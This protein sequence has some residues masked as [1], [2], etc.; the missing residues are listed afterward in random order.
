MIQFYA[1]G[2][3]RRTTIDR[4][5]TERWIGV[6][7]PGTV[8]DPSTLDEG[9]TR[10][11]EWG[12]AVR[13]DDTITAKDR[14]FAGSDET[15]ANA[16]LRLIQDPS[17]GAIWCAR[18]GYGATRILKLLDAGRAPAHLAKNP[19]LLLG[20][21][22]VTA[23]H[24]YFYLHG[25]P[26]VHGP[27][28]GTKA[29]ASL[30]LRTEKILRRILK[31]TMEL[32]AASHTAQWKP[33]FLCAP[34][35]EAEGILVGGSLTLLTSLVGTPW[36]PNLDGAIL[37]LE[38]C[39]EAPYRVDRMLTQLDNAGMLKKIRGVLLGD[40][41]D[42]VVYRDAAER[43]NWKPIFQERFAALNVPVLAGLPFGHAKRNEPVPVGVKAR[44]TKAGKIELLEQPVRA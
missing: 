15:R 44:I 32:G 39:G 8:I 16:L 42:G 33:K 37:F 40:F 11:A 41:E 43:K 17:V 19:K 30:D 4:H 2:I 22:D 36:Q 18:G 20:F 24:L 38:D 26:S 1:G 35:K 28:P 6:A 12:Y 29:W 27:M 31:G 5:V 13:V 14:Y 23:L 7:A 9:L 25:L 21:S 3:M 34:K 10:F